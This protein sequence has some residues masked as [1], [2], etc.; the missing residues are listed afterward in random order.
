[1][2][3]TNSFLTIMSRKQ[4]YFIQRIVHLLYVNIFKKSTPELRYIIN[5]FLHF[6]I[7]HYNV[8]FIKLTELSHFSSIRFF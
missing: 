8:F 2:K 6:F 7:N 1:M 4:S 3:S 5:I